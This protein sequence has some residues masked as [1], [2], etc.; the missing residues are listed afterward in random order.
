MDRKEINKLK[1]RLRYER[2]KNEK[3]ENLTTAGDSVENEKYSDDISCK[4][5][6][7]Y[8]FLIKFVLHSS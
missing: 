4:L 6:R 7:L 3:I 5:M 8:I 2:K 1:R